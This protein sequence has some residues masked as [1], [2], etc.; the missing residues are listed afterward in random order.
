[1]QASGRREG[2]STTIGGSSAFSSCLGVGGGEGAWPLGLSRFW[3]GGLGC[4][5][6]W[7]CCGNKKEGDGVEAGLDEALSVGV[8]LVEVEG[9]GALE[10]GG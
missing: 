9:G 1:M 3:L 2:G 8:S 7:G 4:W 6:R 5:G 10:G